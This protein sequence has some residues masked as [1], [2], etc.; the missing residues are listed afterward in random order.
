[1]PPLPD[2]L[3]RKQAA[4]YL[5]SLGYDISPKTLRNMASKTKLSNTPARKTSVC[6]SGDEPIVVKSEL[7]QKTFRGMTLAI[8]VLSFVFEA[9]ARSPRR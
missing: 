8:S 9:T 7:P 6:E 2:K 1:M 3:S 5:T 4:R